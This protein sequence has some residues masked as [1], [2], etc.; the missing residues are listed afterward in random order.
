M[1]GELHELMSL[2]SVEG[3]LDPQVLG[4]SP[5][6]SPHVT[7]AHN[8]H[9]FLGLSQDSVQTQPWHSESFDDILLL[10]CLAIILDAHAGSLCN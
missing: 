8:V 6:N 9:A 10:L 2:K 3:F 7:V 5:C 4:V 1:P